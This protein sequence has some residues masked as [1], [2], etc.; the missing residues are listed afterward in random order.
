MK[1]YIG[2]HI[3]ASISVKQ[4]LLTD[5]MDSIEAAAKEMVACYRRQGKILAFGNGGSASDAQHFVAELVGRFKMERPALPALALTTNTS[6]LT[7]VA[8]DYSYESI[9]SRQVEGLCLSSDLVLGISTSGRSPNV[10]KALQVAK[11]KGAVCVGLSGLPGLPMADLCDVLIRVPS[12]DTALV[13]E[14]HICIIHI[15]CHLIET[16][17]GR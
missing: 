14:S 17:L 11:D 1:P 5:C 16:E 12:S 9:F 4:A 2:E 7:A 8:N 6:T 13:Q 15:L 3:Q 10:L